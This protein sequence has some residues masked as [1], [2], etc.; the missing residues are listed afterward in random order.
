MPSRWDVHVGSVAVHAVR[1]FGDVREQGGRH[2]SL[3]VPG[4]EAEPNGI[5]QR[6]EVHDAGRVV[7]V[8]DHI[9]PGDPVRVDTSELDVVDGGNQGAENRN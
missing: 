3:Y 6:G 2:M 1:V 9:D 5:C 8:L 7:R 4:S